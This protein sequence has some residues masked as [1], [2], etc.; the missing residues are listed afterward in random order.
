MIRTLIASALLIAVGC[1]S[2]HQYHDTPVSPAPATPEEEKAIREG[3][4]GEWRNWSTI[5]T[6]GKEVEEKTFRVF[7]VFKA[8]GTGEQ[9][10]GD[11]RAPFTWKQDGKNITTTDPSYPTIRIDKVGKDELRFFWYKLSVTLVYKP[12]SAFTGGRR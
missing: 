3:I 11:K 1:A 7:M 9:G 4:L 2:G 5:H 10:L 8:D 12:P 6:D